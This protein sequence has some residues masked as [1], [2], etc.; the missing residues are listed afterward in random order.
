[1]HSLSPIALMKAYKLLGL[2]RLPQSCLA[3][4]RRGAFLHT[5]RGNLGEAKNM[6]SVWSKVL[7]IILELTSTSYWDSLAPIRYDKKE[8]KIVGGVVLSLL[9]LGIIDIVLIEMYLAP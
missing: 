3:A 1:V 4:R 2:E 6:R 5:K 9:A 7:G 8:L